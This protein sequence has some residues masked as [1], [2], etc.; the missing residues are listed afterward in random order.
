MISQKDRSL[1]KSN[2]SMFFVLLFLTG[3]ATLLAVKAQ[4]N[5]IS[6]QPNATLQGELKCKVTA[7]LQVRTEEDN[8]AEDSDTS[9]SLEEDSI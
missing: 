9:T 4:V 2:E 7:L 6:I 8:D 3:E 1:A 5:V